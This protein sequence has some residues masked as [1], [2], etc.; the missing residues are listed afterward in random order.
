MDGLAGKVAL[1]VGVG[2]HMGLAAAERLRRE[3][4]TVLVNDIRE[5]VAQRVAE[6]VSQVA[7]DHGDGSP[8]LATEQLI[9]PGD[10][11]SADDC[12]SMMEVAIS[13]G[14]ALDIVV[15]AAGR[16]SF[17]LIVQ[18]TEEQ[19][20]AEI[21]TNLTGTFLVCQAA[22]RAMI[23][24]D[25]GGR[26]VLFGSGAGS[27]A[28]KGGVSHCA[29]KAGVNLIARVL[30][31]EVG[32]YG[33]TVNVV[34]PGL[35]PKAEQ[36]SRQEYRTATLASTPLG[37]LGEARDVAGAVAFLASDEAG[38]ITGEVLQI[39]GGTHAGSYHI[40]VNVSEPRTR[41]L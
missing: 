32:E 16:S 36:M 15:N 17:G 6:R 9:V 39:D 10:V 1:I 26:I 2:E 41:V 3:G 18:M 24:Q 5:V 28:S 29:A 22:A 38:W 30:A 40:P 13:R 19:F 25:R 33:I 37:R 4:C 34:A 14:G 35:V 27:S 8:S 11:R 7:P 20:N 31:L 23:E 21:S 12:R